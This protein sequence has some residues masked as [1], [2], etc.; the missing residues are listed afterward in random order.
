MNIVSLEAQVKRPIQMSYAAHSLHAAETPPAS[1]GCLMQ[2][3]YI[4]LVLGNALPRH[5]VDLL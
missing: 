3:M 1:K 2:L 5:H 4:A